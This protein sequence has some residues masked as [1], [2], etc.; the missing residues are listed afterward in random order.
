MSIVLKDLVKRFEG[1]AVVNNVSLEVPEGEFFVLLGPSG[2]GK[3]TVLRMIAGLAS[4]DQGKVL[5]HGRDVT[6]VSPRRREVGLVFQHYA[7]FR[8]MSVAENVEFALRIRRVP[9]SERRRRRDDLLALV[10]LGGLG[11]RMPS[12][13]SGG[14]QQRV[15]LARAL[16]HKPAVLLLDEPFGALDAR[17]RTDL[18]RSVRAIQRELGI[19]TIFVTHDQE[20]AFELAD[21][22]GVMSFGRLLETGLPQDLYLRPQTEFVATFL[23][24]AN[25]I[26]GSRDEDGV[27]IGPVKLPLK[28]ES[29]PPGDSRRV[30]VLFRPEDVAVR[31][32]AEALKCPILG[33]AQVEQSAFTG[34]SEKLTLKLPPIPGARMIAPQPSFGG[35]FI[36]IEASR[37]QHDARGFP[38]RPGDSVWVGVRRVHV[39]THPGLHFLVLTDGSTQGRAALLAGAEAGRAAHARVTILAL[40]ADETSAENHLVDSRD[41]IGA[42]LAR[43]DLRCSALPVP[44]ALAA[45][46]AGEDVDLI[47]VGLPAEGRAEAVED[48]LRGSDQHLLLVSD[49]R[50]FPSRVLISVAVGEPGKEDVLF[51]GRF[52]RHFGAEATIVT[53]LPDGHAQTEGEQ[54]ERFLAAGARSLSVLGVSARSVVRRGDVLEEVIREFESGKHEM[55]V[56]GTPMERR[57]GRVSLGALTGGLVER[58]GDKPVLLARARQSAPRR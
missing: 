18:R 49:S 46:A 19:S 27:R 43:V 31:D 44:E 25:L 40:G 38:F 36:R 57:G 13:L 9:P 17:I 16:A 4:I 6:S 39:L 37:S 53:V 52:L 28:P 41:A 30:Q 23:G 2:S 26:V 1:H 50:P 29:N 51:A 32:A 35:D 56:L 21:R 3:S 47:F 15:A 33:T 5:L 22:V 55:L 34:T 7:L 10:G 54:A 12:Q 20:E 42:G 14:Q 58:A 24:T 45:A 8:H 48:V 11:S